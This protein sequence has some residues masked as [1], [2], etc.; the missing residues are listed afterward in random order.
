MNDK[1]RN[2][3]RDKRSPKPKSEM[4][5]YTMSSIKSKNSIP[6]LIIRKE[7]FKQGIRG[8]R[9]HSK[10]VI[11]KPDIAF[12]RKKIAIFINGCFWHMCPKCNLTSPKHNAAFWKEKL[13]NNVERDTK[14]IKLLE[15][16]GWNII[17]IWECD[18]KKNV[19]KC[20]NLIIEKIK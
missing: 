16:N 11:G 7:L 13:T 2:Y 15:E 5:S 18:I 12:L 14:N 4:T 6:E 9:I 17:T 19:E 1:S 10:N 3:I 8:Y 20:L